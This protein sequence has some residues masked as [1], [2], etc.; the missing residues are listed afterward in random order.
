[1]EGVRVGCGRAR[2]GW[3]W[4]APGGAPRVPTAGRQRP[5]KRAKARARR[6][7]ALRAQRA[8]LRE[9]INFF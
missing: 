8:A 5:H 9:L 3:G 4:G 6:G 7:G 2:G 1:M